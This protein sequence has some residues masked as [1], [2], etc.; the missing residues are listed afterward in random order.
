M[1]T[2]EELH[3]CTEKA[4]AKSG[5]KKCNGNGSLGVNVTTGEKVICPCV[6]KSIQ[7]EIKII[8]A[9]KKVKYV[10]NSSDKVKE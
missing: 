6:V 1:L 10:F 8:E 2:A 4:K 7:K 3:R 5:C 9:E